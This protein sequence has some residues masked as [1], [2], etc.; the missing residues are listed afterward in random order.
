[1]LDLTDNA[2]ARFHELII[3]S[4]TLLFFVFSSSLC[5]R[6]A[7]FYTTI[8]VGNEVT[9]W[10]IVNSVFWVNFPTANSTV[11]VYR[12]DA[13][14]ML[15]RVDDSGMM[16]QCRFKGGWQWNAFFVD[17]ELAHGAHERGVISLS[18]T[19]M[20]SEGDWFEWKWIHQASKL[21]PLILISCIN[22]RWK[23]TFDMEV[24]FTH[25]TAVNK[26]LIAS[27]VAK[28]THRIMIWQ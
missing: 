10:A 19:C 15:I 13:L 4:H 27:F 28:I 3:N 23:G 21:M 14:L 2:K 6:I 18:A 22:A 26:T 24:E 12:F 8:H 11:L 20:A 1:M 7:I 25:K 9:V 16:V 17:Q 5:C